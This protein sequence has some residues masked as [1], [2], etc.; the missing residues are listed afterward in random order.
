LRQQLHPIARRLK[1]ELAEHYDRYVDLFKECERRSQAP[2]KCAQPSQS[3]G[4]NGLPSAAPMLASGGSPA[5]AGA[6]DALTPPPGAQG[7]SSGAKPAANP[8]ERHQTRA[9]GAPQVL[10]HQIGIGARKRLE[11]ILKRK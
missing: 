7:C 9:A 5:A 2:S 10:H 3:N 8:N 4:Q 6:S 1:V 11:D